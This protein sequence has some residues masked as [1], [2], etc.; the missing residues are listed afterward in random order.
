V[1][2]QHERAASHMK[3]ADALFKPREPS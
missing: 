1:K 2:A 3:L